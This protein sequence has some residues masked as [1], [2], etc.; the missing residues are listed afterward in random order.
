MN[1]THGVHTVPH[2][3]L[4]AF[5]RGWDGQAF[6]YGQTD[7]LQ[8]AGAWIEAVTGVNPALP[9]A[10][11]YTNEWE[12]AKVLKTEF[13]AT[14]GDGVEAALNRFCVSVDHAMTGDFVLAEGIDG[15]PAAGIVNGH[16]ITAQGQCGLVSTPLL[17]P[18]PG[19]RI[20]RPE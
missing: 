6:A 12:A 13:G 1:S 11:R 17:G 9:F 14:G 5:L 18:E 20:V 19:W 3:R 10:D 16:L 4:G 2:F 15:S 8:Y 7:C